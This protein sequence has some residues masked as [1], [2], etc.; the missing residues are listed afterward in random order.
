MKGLEEFVYKM[1]DSQY[2]INLSKEVS[3]LHPKRLR[4]QLNEHGL[5]PIYR[6]RKEIAR[7]YT[8]KD[9]LRQELIYYMTKQTKNTIHHLNQFV[10]LTPQDEDSLINLYSQFVHVTLNGFRCSESFP[11]FKSHL[12]GSIDRH[13]S[14]LT[15]Y[16]HTIRD[17]HIIRSDS[18]QPVVCHEYTPTLQLRLLGMQHSQIQEPILDIG[19]GSQGRLVR[20]FR[21]Q[22]LEAYGV[23]RHV[24]QDLYLFEADWFE[25]P[26]LKNTWGTILSHMAFSNHFV[27]HHWRKDGQP[28]KY[29]EI[30]M[31]ILESLR[32]KG[33][34]FY[35]PGLP[36]IEEWLPSNRYRLQRT[37]IDRQP[38]FYSTQ[39]MKR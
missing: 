10:H 30:Y 35:V 32:K 20:Y 36:F 28:E 27:H 6:Y 15:H 11:V 37:T 23:D 38:S 39:I 9:D 29:A 24:I 14:F 22:G 5:E 25:F 7:F 34:F 4:L 19:C 2:E 3:E 26:F 1:V 12:R 17:A 16:L 8:Y 31:N 13:S 33:S 21:D 18:F